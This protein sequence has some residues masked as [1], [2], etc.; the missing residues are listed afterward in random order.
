[1]KSP[2]IY[3]QICSCYSHEHELRFMHYDDDIYIS[4]FLPAQ[5]WY[6][7]LWLGIKYIFGYKSSYG[8]FDET[9]MSRETAQE[10][11]SYLTDYVYSKPGEE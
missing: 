1:M 2:K 10:L 5:A 8:H 9:I 11:H 6:N 3:H 4:T 7:R